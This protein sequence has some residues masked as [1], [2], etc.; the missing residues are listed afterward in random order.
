MRCL[1]RDEP[2]RVMSRV[3]I[4]V[5]AMIKAI[6]MMISA[7]KAVQDSRFKIQDSGP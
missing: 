1:Q 3:I 7:S 4:R 6:I 2:I 5:R